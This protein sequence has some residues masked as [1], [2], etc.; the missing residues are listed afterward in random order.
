MQIYNFFFTE[1]SAV[2]LLNRKQIR[3][4]SYDFPDSYELCVL[5]VHPIKVRNYHFSE[6]YVL[7]MQNTQNCFFIRSHRIYFFYHEI[8]D[9]TLIS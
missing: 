1:V 7:E 9:G 5:L 2:N 3:I 4:T 6:T 8:R